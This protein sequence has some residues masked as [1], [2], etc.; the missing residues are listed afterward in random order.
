[1]LDLDAALSSYQ[2]RNFGARHQ[3][4]QCGRTCPGGKQVKLSV[5]PYDLQQ[6]FSEY[7]VLCWKC[8][9]ATV[10]EYLASLQFKFGTLKF[11]KILS[12]KRRGEVHL[13][14]FSWFTLH[15]SVASWLSGEKS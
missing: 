1:M 4:T 11:Y 10:P 13:A 5:R 9:P 3:T 6:L 8:P 15:D 7:F 12:V 14:V 2:S